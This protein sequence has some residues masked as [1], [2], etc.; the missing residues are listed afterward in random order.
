MIS[1]KKKGFSSSPFCSEGK[2][3]DLDKKQIV[4]ATFSSQVTLDQ[5]ATATAT[6]LVESLY[7]SKYLCFV[8]NISQVEKKITTVNLAYIPFPKLRGQI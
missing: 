7:N 6:S 5:S 2:K 8:V 1:P 3:S 4:E